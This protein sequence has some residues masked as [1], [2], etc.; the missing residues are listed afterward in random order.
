MEIA[1]ELQAFRPGDSRQ[2]IIPEG[3]W[4]QAQTT[5]EKLDLVYYY[6]QNEIQ[7]APNPSVSAGD[8]ILLDGDRW[9]VDL[10]GFSKLAD[11]EEGGLSAVY[12][13]LP[14]VSSL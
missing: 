10:V 4:E 3:R 7:E 13:G 5:E 2:V 6:G 12:P 1:V 9:L 14:D 11:G 8:V